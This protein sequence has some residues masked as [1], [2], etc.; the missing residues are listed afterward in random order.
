MPAKVFRGDKAKELLDYAHSEL[1]ASARQKE[2]TL[3]AAEAL[4]YLAKNV[5][6]QVSGEPVEFEQA[7]AAKLREKEVGA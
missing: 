7:Q 5:F 3:E 6:D 4:Y 1:N 2:L